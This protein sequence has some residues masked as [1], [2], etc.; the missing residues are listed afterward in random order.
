MVRTLRPEKCRREGRFSECTHRILAI[1][2]LYSVNLSL[3]GCLIYDRH[4][5]RSEHRVELP[6]RIRSTRSLVSAM[7]PYPGG[8]TPGSSNDLLGAYIFL[9]HYSLQ[10][11]RLS[12]FQ[13]SISNPGIFLKCL[14]IPAI[15]FNPNSIAVDAMKTSASGITIPIL[16]SSDLTK[17]NLFS[18]GISG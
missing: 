18:I 11:K 17:P 3:R 12:Y 6:A 13:F 1:L 2:S 9:L 5:R 4:V 8:L 14:R 16:W 10:T 7:R 15:S